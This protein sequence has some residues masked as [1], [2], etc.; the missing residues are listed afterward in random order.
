MARVLVYNPHDARNPGKKK[1]LT[2]EQV[3]KRQAKAVRFLRDVAD[4][5]DLADE[6][7]DLSV[8]EYAERKG[9]ELINNP[10]RKTEKPM[11]KEELKDAVRSGVIEAVKSIKDLRSNPE[12]ATAAQSTPSVERAP[13]SRKEILDAVD[14]AAAAIADEDVDEALEILNGLLDED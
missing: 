9:F 10:I 12:P 3:E 14:D 7:E 5:P 1:T 11:K 4:D 13:K 2:P 8:R 6:I